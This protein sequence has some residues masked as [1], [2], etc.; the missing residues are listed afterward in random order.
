MNKPL[1]DRSMVISGGSWGIGLAIAV[2]LAKLGGNTVLLVKTD[3]PDPRLPGTI[4]TAVEEIEAAGGRAVP[5]IGDVRNQND[6]QRAV[7]AT[8]T[9][10]GGI[11]ICLNYASV[12][13]LSATVDLPLKRFDLMHEV[14]VRGTFALTQ[15]C[16][17]YL[18]KSDNPH[19]LTLSSPLNLSA[20]WLGAHPGYML[21]KDGMTLLT[22]GWANE[23][24]AISANC[25]WPETLN[26]TAAVANL[27][28]ARTSWIGRA[29]RRSLP[30]RPLG[31]SAPAQARL[32]GNAL[33][34]PNSLPIRELT[35]I[36]STAVPRAKIATSSLTNSV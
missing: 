17:P 15:A 11:D 30:T 32:M 22:Q 10:F 8:V 31:F 24:D 16:L 14:N 35:L 4:H 25:L 29:I 27:T 5:V 2:E 9:Q 18:M 36:D 33:S 23:F 26:A 19:I 3:K 1:A 13:N 6:V 20:K 7:D 28:V 34:M 21:A 12:L